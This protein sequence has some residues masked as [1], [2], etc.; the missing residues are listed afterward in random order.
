MMDWDSIGSFV[1]LKNHVRGTHIASHACKI[2]AKQTHL[3]HANSMPGTMLQRTMMHV[4]ILWI[5]SMHC[6]GA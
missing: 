1:L 5:T 2:H 4:D 3:F 6:F